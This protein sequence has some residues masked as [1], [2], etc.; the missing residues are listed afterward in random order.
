[1]DIQLAEALK[2]KKKENGWWIVKGE[3]TVIPPIL[4]TEL[5]QKVHRETH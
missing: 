3:K 5:A 4:M 2:V 1:M